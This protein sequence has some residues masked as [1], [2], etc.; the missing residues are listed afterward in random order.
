MSQ[1]DRFLLTFRVGLLAE[2]SLAE[3]LKR[4]YAQEPWV[5]N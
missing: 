4:H 1:A 2:L 3:A 5:Q